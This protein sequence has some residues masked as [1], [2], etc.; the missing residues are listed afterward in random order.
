MRKRWM[1]IAAITVATLVG[2]VVLAAAAVL[3]WVDPNDF[4]A[5]IERLAQQKTGRTLRIGGR[6][7]LKLF[8]YLA[9]SIADVRLGNPGGYADEPFA[10]V[11]QASVGVRLLPILRK[12]LEVSRV[13]VDG[14]TAT[15][16]SRSPTDN[17]WRD[18]T[19]PKRNAA[20]AGEAGAT[21]A[22]IAGLQISNSLLV[23]R[24]E[25]QK[26][27]T[28]LSNLKLQTGVLGGTEP[29]HVSL[30][31]DYGDGGR[32]PVAH[33]AIAMRAQMPAD[34]ARLALSDFDVHSEWFGEAPKRATP[35]SFSLRSAAILLDTKDQTLAPATLDVSSGDLSAQLTVA[36]EKLF[37]E[38]LLTGTLTVPRTSP[39]G[40]LEP[41]GVALPTTRDARALSAL[42]ISSDYR[43]TPTQL[44]LTR[45]EL[46]LDDTHVRG[47]A[48]IEDLR[49]LELSYDLQVDAIDVDRYLAPQA[50]PQ[51]GQQPAAPVGAAQEPPISLPAAALRKLDL[52]GGLHIGHATVAGVAVSAVSLPLA[53]KDG[54]VHLGPTQAR[55]FGGAYN[56]DIVLNV[57]PAQ[58]QLSLNEHVR[59]VDASELLK[60]AL[61]TTRLSGRG[62]ANMVVTGGGNTDADILRSLA[63]KIDV[64]V[65]EG[66]INGIDLWYELRRARALL[67]QEAI[68]PRTGPERTPFNTFSGSGNLIRGVLRND[69]L[70]IETDYL[71]AHGKG[72]LDLG[73][74]AVDYRIV[75]SVY[76]LPP[77]GAG[78]EMKDVKAADLPLLI[79]GNL[80]SLKVRPDLEGLAK[81]QVRQEV[82]RK[83][84]EKSDEL[85][86]KLGDKLQDLFGH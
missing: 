79:T 28:S 24:D 25:A 12:R 48:A 56:G 57:A 10:M 86:K 65:R 9:I 27:V 84:Q 46:T 6:L 63:G 1:K 83:V 30:E 78:S 59:D 29:V 17:N 11:H 34:S 75:A 70:S 8:P 14:L 81:A 37:G 53:A 32:E 74:K 71:K 72:T 61:E 39:R 36:G 21:Q 19:E 67:R 22:T 44:R 15:L 52:H 42:S 49:T 33:I 55:V 60:S 51:R 5:D 26:S 76:N 69:D 23:Y 18:L 38:R 4:R 13:S 54:R 50:A 73:T 47:A 31:F 2:L 16:V 41:L 58:A 68:P 40:I 45:L 43:L 62:D 66:A 77:Q 85:K 20:P 82:Q 80:A 7:D 35:L 3:L 64:N